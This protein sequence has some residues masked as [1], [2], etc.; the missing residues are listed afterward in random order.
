M[1]N[2]KTQLTSAEINGIIEGKLVDNEN[3]SVN[4]IGDLKEADTN[5]LAFYNDE[6]FRDQFND[7]KAGL[8]LVSSESA[9]KKT[10]Q[11]IT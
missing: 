7:S 2:F 8:I 6:K 1:K 11:E 3:I 9:V 4:S 10:N 5:T